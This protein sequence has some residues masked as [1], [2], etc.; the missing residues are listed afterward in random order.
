MI[1]IKEILRLGVG[2]RSLREVTRLAGVDRKT[3]RRYVETARA[4]G[5]DRDGG[6]GQLTDELLAAVVSGARPLRP[7]GRVPGGRHW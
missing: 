1:E 7:S 5:M 3:V 2:G 4:C 6:A